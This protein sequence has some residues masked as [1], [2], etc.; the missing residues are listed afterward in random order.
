MA[1]ELLDESMSHSSFDAFKQVDIYAF[2]LVLWEIARR[3]TMNG[4]TDE[5]QVPY[6]DVLYPDPLFDDVRRVVCEEKTR[7]EQPKRWL[8]VGSVANSPFRFSD[9][10]LLH[11]T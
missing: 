11:Y 7:P 10:S 6:H 8:Q 9:L 5:Y 2:G 4:H 1:P 3:C